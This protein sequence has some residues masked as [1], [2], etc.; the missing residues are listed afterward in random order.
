MTTRRRS[1]R[2]RRPTRRCGRARPYAGDSS[3]APRPLPMSACAAIASASS[4]NAA[5]EKMVNAT[6]QP[7]SSSVPERVGRPTVASS[8]IR[9]DTVRRNS[10]PPESRRAATPSRCGGSD[11]TP[12]GREP[13]DHDDVRGDHAPLRDHGADGR[14]GDP[15]AEAVDEEPVQQRRWRRSRCRAIHSGV[16]VSCIPRS[17]PVAAKTM[18]I[19]GSPHIEMPR[20]TDASAATSVVAPN[21]SHQRG[22]ASSRRRRGRH[23]SRVRATSRRCPTRRRRVHRRLRLAARPRASS[24]TRGTPSARRS[25]AARRWRCR[26]RRAASRRGGRPARSRRSG[27]AARR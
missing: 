5:V 16:T 3:P 14:P 12:R 6:C 7:A 25:S 9:S 26:G 8:A 21:S 19:A 2:T 11:R 15:P 20:Y 23:R 18:S 10:Q 4:A 17:S 27:T 1:P 24:R 22:V 13:A